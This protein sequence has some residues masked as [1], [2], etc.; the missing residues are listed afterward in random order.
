MKLVTH[1]S[2]ESEYV[3]LSEAGNEAVY[4]QQLQG[5]MRIGKQSVLSLGENESSLKLAMNPVF[6]QR[7]KH[8]RIK[9]HSLRN[10]VK[11]RL[12]ELR[13]VDTGIY[14]ADMTKNV[15]VGVLKMCKGLIGMVGSDYTFF[16][17]GCYRWGNCEV[18]CN[19]FVY[20]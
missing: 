7:S 5:E 19:I 14:A 16:V 8:I 15:G 12:I 10:R 9:Y 6:H 3:G 1:S 2:C 11:E 4:L 18:F 17:D 20:Y 13:K